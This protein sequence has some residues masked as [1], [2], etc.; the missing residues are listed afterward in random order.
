MHTNTLIPIKIHSNMGG[1]VANVLCVS[2]VFEFTLYLYSLV[3]R[4]P[5]GGGYGVFHCGEFMKCH[6][7]PV[8][9]SLR[10]AEVIVS[11][12]TVNVECKKVN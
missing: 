4:K 5:I 12:Y 8:F 2:F 6:N 1:R 9:Y 3:T 10:F 7:A 11:M